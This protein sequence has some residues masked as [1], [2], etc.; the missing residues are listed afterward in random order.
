MI[1]DM[2]DLGLTYA[3]S[4]HINA[5]VFCPVGHVD[6]IITDDCNGCCDYCFMEGRKPRRMSLETAK[7]SVDLLI[8]YSGKMNRL[9][10]LFFGGEPLLEF[11]L[12]RDTIAYCEQRSKETGKEFAFSITTNGTLL[13][14]EILNYLS[15]KGIKFLLSLDGTREMHNKHRK[16]KSGESPWDIVVEKLP[17]F[18]RYQPWQGTRLTLMPDTAG[19]LVEGVLD[20]YKRG[21][22]QFIIGPAT[23]VIW[24]KEECAVYEEQL[25][26]L[27]DI[28]LEK[29]ARNEPF[30]M[31]LF[32]DDIEKKAEYKG[33]WGCGAGRGR[34][35][36]APNGEIQ[37]CAKVQGACDSKGFLPL[38]NV[39]DGISNI[40][41][42]MMFAHSHGGKR[43]NCKDCEF[44][45]ECAGGCPAV[46]LTETGNMFI[47]SAHHCEFV[48]IAMR[49][50]EHLRNHRADDKGE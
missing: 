38:G 43:V 17:Y 8:D 49:L 18:K 28:Y 42:R 41:N 1:Q 48:R 16:L 13:T 37:S 4:R 35:S 11:G 30:R 14:P 10:L 3:L 34:I 32:E 20:L 31:T 50:R 5:K 6:L 12:M 45:D 19:Q 7:K 24:T 44:R 40:N 25:F 26:K 22:N 2:D 47:P 33:F 46:N 9:N 21:L 15:R 29:K 27:A 23:G 36:I 39:A